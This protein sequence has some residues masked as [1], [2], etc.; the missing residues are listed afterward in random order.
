MAR[1]EY[2]NLPPIKMGKRTEEKLPDVP[3]PSGPRFTPPQ[4]DGVEQETEIRDG[5]Q[6]VIQDLFAAPKGAADALEATGTDA[7]GIQRKTLRR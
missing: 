3:M 2:E 6:K 5:K 7:L 4:F 1:G